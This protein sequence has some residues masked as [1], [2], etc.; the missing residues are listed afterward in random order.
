M[1]SKIFQILINTSFLKTFIFNI[2]YLGIR[3]LSL[4][5]LIGK[6]VE[7]KCLKANLEIKNCGFASI[8]IGTYIP[9]NI[10][11]RTVSTFD[12]KG[13]IIFNGKTILG[14]GTRFCNRGVVEFGDNFMITA[15]SS[16]LCSNGIKFVNN[17]IVSL[18]CEIM[19]TDFHKIYN[20]KNELLNKNST[21]C[22]G[23]KNWLCSGV[24]ILKNCKFSKETVIGANSCIS[25]KVF[26]ESN[27]LICGNGKII[28]SNI[29]WEP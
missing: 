7:L 18:N 12:N 10:P 27:C 1:L 24:K 9:G 3:G 17:C 22:F 13:T 6:N 26:E 2:H 29:K 5:I 16:I 4:P 21:I 23:D 19:D 8:R 15:N 28:K 11:S 25:G 14:V 20:N